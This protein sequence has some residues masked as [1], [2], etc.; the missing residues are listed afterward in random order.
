MVGRVVGR[1]IGWV[2][3]RVIGRG[4]GR[5]AGRGVVVV[6]GGVTGQYNGNFG[7]IG[8]E[9]KAAIEKIR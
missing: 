3:G 2:M 5:V 4:V 6:G 9:G 1:V 7:A 8:N